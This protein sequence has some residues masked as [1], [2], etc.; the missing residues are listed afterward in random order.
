MSSSAFRAVARPAPDMPVT[1]TNG[2][3][4]SCRGRVVAFGHVAARDHASALCIRARRNLAG[5]DASNGAR[6][7]SG[8]STPSRVSR[9]RLGQALDALRRHQVDQ[10]DDAGTGL[11]TPARQRH[12]AH[13]AHLDQAGDARRRRGQQRAGLACDLGLVVGDQARAG[14]DQAQRQVRL[15]GAGRAAQQHCAPAAAVRQG[16]AGGVHAHAICANWPPARGW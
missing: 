6:A 7:R 13:A 10:Q 14:I 3:R 2:R 11:A 8:S 16:H 4:V 12:D 15:A 5:A 9:G 1:S